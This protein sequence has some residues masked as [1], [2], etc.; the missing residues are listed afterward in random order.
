[1]TTTYIY[2]IILQFPNVKTLVFCNKC[3][4]YLAHVRRTSGIR[5]AMRD[6]SEVVVRRDSQC[7]MFIDISRVRV[8][9]REEFTYP[10]MLNDGL[11]EEHVRIA[12][13]PKLTPGNRTVNIGS[14]T[15]GFV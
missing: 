10:E 13:Y 7:A 9:L 5:T 8:N 6:F 3:K 1:M 2:L 12:H 4:K 14:E 15:V 11:N